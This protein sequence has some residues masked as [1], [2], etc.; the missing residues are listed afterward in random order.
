M[1]KNTDIDRNNM[2]WLIQSCCNITQNRAVREKTRCSKHVSNERVI[3]RC[4]KTELGYY[5]L[6]C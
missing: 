2:S 6:Q 4:S 5:V 3:F 1:Y